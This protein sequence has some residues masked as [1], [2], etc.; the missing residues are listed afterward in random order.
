VVIKVQDTPTSNKEINTLVNDAIQKNITLLPGPK[1]DFLLKKSLSLSIIP[2]PDDLK[3]DSSVK[4]SI[5]S[6]VK[7]FS[8]LPAPCYSGHE[9]KAPSCFGLIAADEVITLG[10]VN[11]AFIVVSGEPKTY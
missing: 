5:S 3:I 8:P 9:R 6:K 4:V 10:N 11:I 7:D 1:D 2:L